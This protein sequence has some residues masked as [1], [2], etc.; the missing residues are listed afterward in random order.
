MAASAG[1]LATTAVRVVTPPPDAALVKTR[2]TRNDTRDALARDQATPD[3]DDGL[4]RED[5]SGDAPREEALD[6]TAR[7]GDE[8]AALDEAITV[9][10]AKV[11][12]AGVERTRAMV[13]PAP[14]DGYSDAERSARQVSEQLRALALLAPGDIAAMVVGR[15]AAGANA[16][17]VD[18]AV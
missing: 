7:A 9:R 18:V 12:R 4:V 13:S 16:G 11:V 1:A 17:R 3:R 8:R 10:H 15:I 2:S 14:P 5:A 6:E